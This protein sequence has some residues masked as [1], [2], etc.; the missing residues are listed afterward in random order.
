ML[1]LSFDSARNQILV[2]VVLEAVQADNG[3]AERCLWTPAQIKGTDMFFCIKRL[4]LY[5]W[6]LFSS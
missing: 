4:I 5:Y 6:A 1:I 2:K 3:G